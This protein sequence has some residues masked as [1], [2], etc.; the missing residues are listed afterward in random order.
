MDV[1]RPE[2]A[3]NGT[4]CAFCNYIC[5]PRTEAIM[6][7]TATKIPATSQTAQITVALRDIAFVLQMT[8]RVKSAII[9]DQAEPKASAKPVVKVEHVVG[10]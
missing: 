7:A 9:A 3:P 2:S 6:T 5:P 4:H 1:G 10:V 8:R